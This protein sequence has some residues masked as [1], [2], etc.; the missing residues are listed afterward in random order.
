MLAEER[1]QRQDFE[2]DL[3]LL[4][5][6]RATQPAGEQYEKT[7]AWIDADPVPDEE[8]NDLKMKCFEYEEV[9]DLVDLPP[10]LAK[11]RFTGMMKELQRRSQ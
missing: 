4:P 11:W 8:V 3:E 9:A 2:K 7:C 5:G 6:F 1:L 10:I